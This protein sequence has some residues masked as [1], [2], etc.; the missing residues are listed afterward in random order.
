MTF[1]LGSYILMEKA[2]ILVAPNFLRAEG[3]SS[4]VVCF[5]NM[6]PRHLLVHELIQIRIFFIYNT[7][8]QAVEQ[9]VEALRYKAE[10]R[11]FDSRWCHCNFSLT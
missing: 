2:S 7:L 3:S 9:L 5:L 4:W 11:R 1:S 6:A 8:G 10:G